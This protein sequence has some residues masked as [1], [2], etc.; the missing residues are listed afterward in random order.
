MIAPEARLALGARSLAR[1]QLAHDF[2]SYRGLSHQKK[3]IYG[4]GDGTLVSET[5]LCVV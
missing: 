4:V 5:K 2:G 3:K 1:V